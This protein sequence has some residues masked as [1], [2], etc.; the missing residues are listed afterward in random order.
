[1]HVCMHAQRIAR[2][3]C[4]HDFFPYLRGLPLREV[5]LAGQVLVQLPVGRVPVV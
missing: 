3:R 4:V 1:M 2:D 5:A